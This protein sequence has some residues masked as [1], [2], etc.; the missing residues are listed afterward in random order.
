MAVSFLWFVFAGLAVFGSLMYNSGMKLGS[1]QINVFAF[2]S[3]LT[4]VALCGNLIALMICKY[5][6]KQDMVLSSQE[7]GFRMAFLAG[8]GIFIIDASYFLAMR[9]G[10]ASASQA[11]WTIGGLIAFSL[12]ATFFFHEVM[13]VQKAFGIV[14]GVSG[15]FLIIRG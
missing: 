8:C 15:L 13:S 9:Y 2:T 7:A 10:S 6:L 11:V 1:G 14:L 3:I 5:G 12:F 4:A